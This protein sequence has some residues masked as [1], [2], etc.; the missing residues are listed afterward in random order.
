[1]SEGIQTLVTKFAYQYQLS[2]TSISCSH[3]QDTG[4]STST[5]SG[6]NVAVSILFLVCLRQISDSY[7]YHFPPTIQSNDPHHYLCIDGY[8]SRPSRGECSVWP[9]G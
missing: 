8:C 5:A 6:L 9:A 4:V 7:L 2:S 1:M 3:F